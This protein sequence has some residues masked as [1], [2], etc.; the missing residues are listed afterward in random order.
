[1]INLYKRFNKLYTIKINNIKSVQCLKK[2]VMD[3]LQYFA[4][5]TYL[6]KD[7]W[8]IMGNKSFVQDL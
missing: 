5:P 2:I 8:K 6:K 4:V 3:W 7:K 1:M